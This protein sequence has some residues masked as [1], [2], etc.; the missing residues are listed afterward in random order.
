MLPEIDIELLSFDEAVRKW[1]KDEDL[2]HLMDADAIKTI[3]NKLR[4][5]RSGINIT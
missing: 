5:R 1:N 3:L 2:K 4:L